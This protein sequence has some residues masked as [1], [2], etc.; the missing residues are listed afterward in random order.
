MDNAERATLP[1]EMFAIVLAFHNLWGMCTCIY[2]LRTANRNTLSLEW[3]V[4]D[5][6]VL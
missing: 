4:I 6:K 2:L 1:A 5:R 3:P